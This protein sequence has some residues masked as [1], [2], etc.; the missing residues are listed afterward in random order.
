MGGVRST[1]GHP[2]ATITRFMTKL[3]KALHYLLNGTPF[4]GVIYA[5]RFNSLSK[6]HAPQLIDT[7]LR[8]APITVASRSPQDGEDFGS[9]SFAGGSRNCSRD[10]SDLTSSYGR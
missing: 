4:E 6:A 1:L 5:S 2:Q 8:I 10:L 3:G 7:I 9:G